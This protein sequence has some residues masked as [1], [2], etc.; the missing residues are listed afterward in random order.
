[1]SSVSRRGHPDEWAN[2]LTAQ[3][4]LKRDEGKSLLK[5][6]PRSRQQGH[7]KNARLLALETDLA[8]R[9]SE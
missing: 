1:M 5:L 6:V 9:D 7:R 8:T 3:R 4:R 2:V